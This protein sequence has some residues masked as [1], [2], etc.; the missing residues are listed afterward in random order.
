MG[1]AFAVNSLFY[2]KYTLSPN[3]WTTFLGNLK[4]LT[5][6]LYAAMMRVQGKAK[7]LGDGHPVM[8][9]IER[10][11]LRYIKLRQAEQEKERVEKAENRIKIDKEATERIVKNAL[12]S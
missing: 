2:C 8:G 10:V 3:I 5:R 4:L 12:G 6:V 7:Q 1:L 9:Q 11:K